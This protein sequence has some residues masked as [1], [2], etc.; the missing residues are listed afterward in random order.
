MCEAAPLTLP[1]RLDRTRMAAGRY[2]SEFS[3]PVRFDDL[4]V[5]WH[6]NN[7]AA[8]I[9]LQEARICFTMELNLP[10]IESPGARIVVGAM[11]T[12]YA[13]EI[14]FP[15]NVEIGTGVVRLGDTSFTFGQLIRQSGL[16]CVYSLVTMVVAGAE[17]PLTIPRRLRQAFLEKAMVIL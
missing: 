17:G 9:M 4:D 1:G 12:E 2:P 11:V 5:Q 10:K 15:G 13:A 3:L 14:N 6:V 8:I 7:A 16:P